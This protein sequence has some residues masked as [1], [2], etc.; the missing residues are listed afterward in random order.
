L[1]LLLL[2]LRILKRLIVHLF[3][4]FFRIWSIT[5]WYSL[6]LFGIA[7]LNNNYLL[8]RILLL[9]LL[10]WLLGFWIFI[11]ITHI[12]TCDDIFITYLVN[13]LSRFWVRWNPI[14]IWYPHFSCLLIWSVSHLILLL[15]ILILA[16]VRIQSWS[17]KA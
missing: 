2:L 9:L 7:F 4:F 12:A 16:P 1:I 17:M 15:I 13:V 3:L 6:L 5:T 14:V 11:D 8:L 10:H